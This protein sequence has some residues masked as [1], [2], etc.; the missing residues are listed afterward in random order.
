MSKPVSIQQV[1]VA[2][3]SELTAAA[4]SLLAV[5]VSVS[6][7]AS[8]DYG[9]LEQFGLSTQ[10]AEAVASAMRSAREISRR[11]EEINGKPYRRD[12]HAKA[13]GC[14]RGLFEV[15]GDIP[16][17]FRHSVFASPAQSYEAWVR[18]SNGDMLVQPDRKPD[19]RGMAIK[20]M[21][22][23]GERIAPELPDGGTQDFIA[24]NTKA[25]FNRNIFDYADD[26]TYLA[27]F[28]RTRWFV[29]FFPPRLHPKQF[30]RAIQTV[31]SKIDNPLQAQYYSMLPY[32]L[33]NST[34][35]F[36]MRA[37]PGMQFR[38]AT[39]K[40]N[41][42]YLSTELEHSLQTE[43]ACF[44]FMVQP[45][46]SGSYMPIDDATVVWSEEDSP[47]EP[48]ARLTLPPQTLGSDEQREFCENISMNPW[49]AVGE[50]EPLGSL[51][52]ARRAVY[53]AVSRYRH[54]QN[55]T[56]ASEPS[57]WC[58]KTSLE[59]GQ[60]VCADKDGV[61]TSHPKWPLPREFDS[62]YR[63]LSP[64]STAE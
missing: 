23:S 54:A 64:A 30:Y 21:N 31:S 35:K 33:G 27:K 52:I 38:D 26:M 16:E 10:E 5:S 3:R 51:G 25:F 6:V 42:D 49:H 11:A 59:G 40:Q 62:L 13:T 28:E 47:F 56:V 8:D 22:V 37:C 58:M 34:V 53:Q 14:V 36:S 18:F 44:D 43:G 46:V 20:L 4:L 55:K 9:D 48:I 15:N 29:S 45:Q 60:T 19:A 7:P 63:P 57:S 24:T 12:A 50:W 1:G 32:R 2:M 17:R 41:A 61:T 39:D